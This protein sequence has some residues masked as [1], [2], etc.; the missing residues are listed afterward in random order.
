[1]RDIAQSFI[2]FDHICLAGY[3]ATPAAFGRQEQFDKMGGNN[4]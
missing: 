1:V 2:V 4:G 3:T